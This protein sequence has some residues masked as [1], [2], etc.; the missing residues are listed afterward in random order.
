MKRK[1]LA[2]F[3]T[4][5]LLLSTA[6]AG[7]SDNSEQPVEDIFSLPT[8]DTDDT[9]NAASILGA[10]S[11]GGFSAEINGNKPIVYDGKPVT[12]KVSVSANT[13][14]KADMSIGICCNINGIFQSLSGNGQENQTMIICEGIAPGESTEFDVTFDPQ[15][16]EEDADKKQVSMSFATSFN[17]TYQASESFIGYGNTHNIQWMMPSRIEFKSKPKTV[18]P[19][20]TDEYT[21]QLMTDKLA[22]ELFTETKYN[23][24]LSYDYIEQQ[25]AQSAALKLS[26]DGSLSFTYTS[27]NLEPGTYR[28][29]LLKN[30]QQAA[31]NGG[32][33]YIEMT[34][35]KG[36]LYTAGIKPDEVQRGDAIQCVAVLKDYNEEVFPSSL[37]ATTP[38]LVV[39]NDYIGATYD[40][41][42]YSAPE[43]IPEN[44][45]SLEPENT[46]PESLPRLKECGVL[47]YYNENGSRIALLTDQYGGYMYMYDIEKNEVINTF[48]SWDIGKCSFLGNNVVYDSVTGTTSNIPYEE[49]DD[50]DYLNMQITD[51]YFIVT[52]WQDAQDDKPYGTDYL[53]YDRSFDLV[54]DCFVSESSWDIYF[55]ED[56]KYKIEIRCVNDSDD[57][58]YYEEL[59]ITDIES[60]K[61]TKL[62]ELPKGKK[63]GFGNNTVIKDGLMYTVLSN[64]ANDSEFSPAVIDLNTGEIITSDI[65]IEKYSGITPM[66]IPTENYTLYLSGKGA[67]DC[68]DEGYIPIFDKQ[69]RKFRQ[70]K[71]AN[72]NETYS[73]MITPD[74]SRIIALS[75]HFDLSENWKT[76]SSVRI[77]DT[78]TG[79][80]LQT[81][82]DVPD[83][84]SAAV[85]CGNDKFMLPSTG[86]NKLY[87]IGG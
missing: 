70:I 75:P 23:P 76:D 45:E 65:E 49:C 64:A 84:W 74:G 85:I 21:E 80:L 36:Y 53:I 10:Y 18:S 58:D 51:K 20:F 4:S 12:V 17:P 25:G 35:K 42:Q 72:L 61:K 15:V 22:D 6:C 77:Y 68:N 3:L 40:D 60:D 8:S 13:D 82:E 55:S 81:I 19:D 29:I 71:T 48:Y 69:Q 32:K 59:Y 7:T 38:H 9:D 46:D 16:L 24:D 52:K 26:D 27:I 41:S 5:A 57:P 34:V 11:S 86:D 54:D 14:N 43:S 73:C 28:I 78:A 63:H 79:E 50:I 87:D 47:G 33:E 62:C 56:D 1:L 2:L 44:T 37:Q 30:N 67:P 83:V 31:F 66:I 39:G